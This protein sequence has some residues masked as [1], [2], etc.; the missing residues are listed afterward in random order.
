VFLFLL[1]AVSA[2][3]G[4]PPTVA[5]NGLTTSASVPATIARGTTATITASVTSTVSRGVLIDVEVYNAGGAKVYQRW[6]DNRSL[7]ANQTS[8]VTA[9]WQVPPSQPTGTYIVKIGVFTPGWASLL[10]WNNRAATFSVAG[11]ATPPTP[12]P[13]ATP[14]PSPST[15]PTPPPSQ[16][17]VTLPPGSAL[18]SNQECATRVRRSSW[19]PRPQN[20]QANNTKP[21]SSQLAALVPWTR[22]STGMDDRADALRRRIDGNFTGTTDEIIQWAACKWG[23][24]EDIVRAVAVQES[25]WRQSNQGDYNPSTGQYESYGLLQVRAPYH[26]VTFPA[27]RDSTPF[28]VDYTLAYRRSCYEGYMLWL[29]D[30]QPGAGYRAGDEWGCVGLWFDGRWKTAAANSYVS[31]VQGHLS[32]RTW[33]QPGF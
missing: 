13:T 23:F 16:K 5:A 32:R 8:R 27:S 1:G 9:T 21:T 20:A 10:D 14:S 7:V 33:A 31:S 15:A 26:R 6:W 30:V 4:V 24:D 11:G 29:H 28:N 2:G 25:W 3:R 22:N 12:S 19:E 17:F 18:P